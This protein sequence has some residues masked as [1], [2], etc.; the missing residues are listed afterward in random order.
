ML[1]VVVDDIAKPRN[2]IGWVHVPMSLSGWYPPMGLKWPDPVCFRPLRSQH[3][4]NYAHIS[5]SITTNIYI[6]IYIKKNYI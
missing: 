3:S 1:D 5:H 6:Y 2:S 4:I